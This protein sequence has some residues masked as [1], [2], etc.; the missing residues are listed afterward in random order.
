[1]LVDLA[2]TFVSLLFLMVFGWPCGRIV[3]EDVVV[4]WYYRS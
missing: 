1:V 4:N 3:L 2:S